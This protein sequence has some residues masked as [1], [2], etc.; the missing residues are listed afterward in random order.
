MGRV[1]SLAASNRRRRNDI[2]TAG[3]L[4]KRSAYMSKD[5]TGRVHTPFAISMTG[6]EMTFLGMEVSINKAVSYSLTRYLMKSKQATGMFS[7]DFDLI[8]YVESGTVHLNTV[9][10]KNGVR[11][12]VNKSLSAGFSACLTRNEEWSIGSGQAGAAILLVHPNDWRERVTHHTPPLD[13]TEVAVSVDYS[14]E[15]ETIEINKSSGPRRRTQEERQRIAEATGAVRRTRDNKRKAAP[16]PVAR[17]AQEVMPSSGATLIDPK[18]G[19]AYRS[20]GPQPIDP[21]TLEAV[22]AGQPTI[23]YEV[24]QAKPVEVLSLAPAPKQV[25]AKKFTF[26]KK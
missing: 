17:T 21:R 12:L 1:N 22:G 13:G 19:I 14:A 4:R 20:L 9:E 15:P 16:E 6:S 7:T 10:K 26:K 8:L 23:T 3:S 24:P 11:N 25:V 5:S 18:T 2:T